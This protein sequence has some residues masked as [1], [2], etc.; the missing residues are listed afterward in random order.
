MANAQRMYPY[1]R[2]RH[3]SGD[4]EERAVHERIEAGLARKDDAIEGAG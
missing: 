1:V 4:I 2:S 3:D